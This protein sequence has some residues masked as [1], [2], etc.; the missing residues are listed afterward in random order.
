M[1]YQQSDTVLWQSVGW[2]T[3]PRQGSELEVNLVNRD[4]WT[5]TLDVGRFGRVH[6]HVRTE[7]IYTQ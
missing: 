6:V 7:Q 2:V 5:L 3:N 1:L 4:R